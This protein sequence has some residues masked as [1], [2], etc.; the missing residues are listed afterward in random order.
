M[1]VNINYSKKLKNEKASNLILFTN[2]KFNINSLKKNISNSEIAYVSD[3]LKTNDTKKNLLTFEIN[4]K[5]RLVLISIKSNLKISEIEN[6][7]AKFFT[8]TKTRKK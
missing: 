4:S 6:L 7:G 5:K 8:Y 3:L 1:L 2:E